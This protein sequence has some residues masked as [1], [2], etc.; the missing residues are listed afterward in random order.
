[1]SVRSRARA[2][3]ALATATA[4]ALAV[5]APAADAA[6]ARAPQTFTWSGT[7]SAAGVNDHWSDPGNWQ[8]GVAPMAA[9]PVNLVFPPLHCPA[10]GPCGNG[11]V[12]DLTGVQVGLA[13]DPDRGGDRAGGGRPQL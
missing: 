8:G 7:D 5:I 2:A 10:T 12:N 11:S 9:Q 1:M 6:A 4:A 3:G 13:H